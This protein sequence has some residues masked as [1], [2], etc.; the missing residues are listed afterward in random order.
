MYTIESLKELHYVCRGYLDAKDYEGFAT[1]IRKGLTMETD[2]NELKTILI[3]SQSFKDH[4]II[5]PPLNAV[6]EMFNFK[7]KQLSS[8]G[9]S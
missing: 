7:M 6:Q 1:F 3:I 8:N 5:G 4:P 2:I 9:E